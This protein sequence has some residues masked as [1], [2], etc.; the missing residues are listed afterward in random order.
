MSLLTFFFFFFFLMIRR[1]P[2]STPLSLHDALPISVRAGVRGFVLKTQAGEDLAQAIEQVARGGV[3]VG[4]G[5]SQGGVGGL[6]AG[7][8]AGRGRPAP[9]GRPGGPRG[10]EGKATEQGAAPPAVTPKNPAVH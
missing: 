2:R 6:R 4:A 3:Y 10:A 9:P 5:V 7:A 1:P 8:P